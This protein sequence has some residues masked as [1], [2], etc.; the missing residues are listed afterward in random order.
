M[1]VLVLL[2]AWPIAELFVAIQ[3]AG[4]IGVL[5]TVLLLILSWPAG[6]WL[7]RAEG[8]AAWRRLST[9]VATGRPPA[10]E[11]IDGGLVLAGGALLIVPGF[12]TDALG[13]ALLLGPTRSLARG[14]IV[15]NFRSR[16]VVRA[17]RLRRP[18]AGYD[19]DS[20][21]TDVDPAELRR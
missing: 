1:F 4:L 14:A 15:R 3:V 8:L 17:T 10:R 18:S 2:I 6:V 12:I 21:A 9:A 13:L 19:V 20:T 16:L 5:A 11:V 7:M